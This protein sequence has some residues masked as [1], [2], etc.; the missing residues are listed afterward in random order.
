MH[1][2]YVF[3]HGIRVAFENQQFALKQD[4]ACGRFVEPV[5]QVV[6]SVT[7]TVDDTLFKDA[8]AKRTVGSTDIEARLFARLAVIGSDAFSVSDSVP[9]EIKRILKNFTPFSV[10]KRYCAVGK[11]VAVLH[12]KA[13][14]PYKPFLKRIPFRIIDHLQAG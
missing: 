4:S 11:A 9:K 8:V 14:A 12:P 6:R 5:I 7:L 2:R 13:V 10:K 3:A 1:E